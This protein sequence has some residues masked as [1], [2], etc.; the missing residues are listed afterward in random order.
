M[1]EKYIRYLEYF[2]DI[3]R[4][5]LIR[6][7]LIAKLADGVET[8]FTSAEERV[9]EIIQNPLLL[10]LIRMLDIYLF[11]SKRTSKRDDPVPGE[12][13]YFRSTSV[14]I[15][16]SYRYRLGKLLNKTIGTEEYGLYLI[17]SPEELMRILEKVRDKLLESSEI[18][19]IIE[20]QLSLL[21]KWE[22][23]IVY[24]E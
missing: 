10:R 1:S 19:M 6:N 20:G 13:E 22:R 7:I 14:D 15:I 16:R 11:H 2:N 12:K 23:G 17:S 8:T 3:V 9:N 18:P 24:H 5:Y 4:L 21:L